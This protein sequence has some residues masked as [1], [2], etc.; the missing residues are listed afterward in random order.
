VLYSVLS[1]EAAHP[2][3]QSIDRY[4]VR[5]TGA[6][7]LQNMRWGGYANDPD[8]IGLMLNMACL[9]MLEICESICIMLSNED[10]MKE[11]QS[12]RVAHDRL[13]GGKL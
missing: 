1:K 12:H 6:F 2:S 4:F 7:P 11:V 9:A 8:E 10:A 3:A 13:N 5:G